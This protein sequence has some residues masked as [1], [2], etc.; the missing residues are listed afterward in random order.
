M[1]GPIRVS[2]Y[3]KMVGCTNQNIYKHLRNYA[4]ELEGH[5]H[6][7]R[8]G[9]VLDEYA[10]EFLRS[11]MYPKELGDASLV[12]EINDLRRQLFLASQET[13][14]LLKEVTV[15]TGERDKALLD[16]GEQQRLLEASTADLAAAK[17]DAQAALRE[18]AAVAERERLTQEALQEATERANATQ[19]ALDVEKT[20]NEALRAKIE[21]LESRTFL[22]RLFNLGVN[23]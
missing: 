10:Q 13:T 3:A 16:A 23:R 14:R 5:V 20:E 11:V 22:Q 6:E 8:R 2:D 12:E 21:A 4:K 18:A 1:N 9:K 15:L 19:N 17:A 7:T